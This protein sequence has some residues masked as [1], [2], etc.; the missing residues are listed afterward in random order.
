VSTALDIGIGLFALAAAI[1]GW[2]L[3]FVRSAL[4]LAGF[5]G[6]AILGGRLGPA[7][8]AG[9]SDSRYAA[10]IALLVALFAGA[11]GASLMDVVATRLGS[12]RL[13]VGL[14][15]FLDSAG[16]TAL[17]LA[18]ALLVA[19]AFSV[20]VLQATAPGS[21]DLR[22]AFSHSKI[23]TA[24]NDELPP[25]GILLNVLRRVDPAPTVKAPNAQVPAP[26]SK[27]VHS[28][29]ARRAEGS[30]VKVIG[31]ACGLGL[32]GSGWAAKS[33]L[34]VTNAHVVAGEDDTQVV[35]PSGATLDA[36]V[37]HYEPTND[38]AILR[39][40]GLGLTGLELKPAASG[41]SAAIVGYPENGPLTATA[42]RMGST[43]TVRTQDSYGRGPINRQVTPFRGVVRS[44]NSGGPVLDAHGRVAATVFAANQSGPP[45]GLGVPDA[46]VSKALHGPLESTGTGPCI[47]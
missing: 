25:S 44:G 26:D 43:G 42:A 10:V 46:A 36:T 40:E 32:E 29:A 8:L 34:V 9:G 31:T 30:V 24:L 47:A 27:S 19:W 21:R 39:V 4:P 6:G 45:G 37:V 41:T 17:L 38:I 18:L 13:R 1:T 35:V 2:Q 12:G 3:G 11:V 5:I 15:A 14:I 22:R 33:D 7:L 23:L 20:V 28:A 16:G